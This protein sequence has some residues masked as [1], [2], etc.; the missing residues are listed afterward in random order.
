MRAYCNANGL[1]EFGMQVP[2]GAMIIA[3][4][5]EEPLRE[6]IESTARHGYAVEMINGRRTKVP[7]SDTLLVP[8]VPEAPDQGAGLMALLRYRQWIDKNA[9]AYGVKVL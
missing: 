2:K 7:G 1:I 4:G 8:G 3:E 5:E 9:Q 6:F